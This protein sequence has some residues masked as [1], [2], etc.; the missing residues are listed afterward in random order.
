MDIV[1]PLLK[2]SRLNK[3]ILVICDS[4][5]R[6]LFGRDATAPIEI[7]PNT[8]VRQNNDGN[9]TE[10]EWHKAKLIATDSLKLTRVNKKISTT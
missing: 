5:N 6:W 4:L 8:R 1:D 10:K 7:L 9:D 3:Y 2:N